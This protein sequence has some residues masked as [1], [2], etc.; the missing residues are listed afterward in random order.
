[1]NWASI[2]QARFNVSGEV[3]CNFESF[4]NVEKK[5]HNLKWKEIAVMKFSGFVK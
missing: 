2:L 4:L 1:M 3:A 5:E